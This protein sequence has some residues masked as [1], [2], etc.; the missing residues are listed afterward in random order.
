MRGIV[1]IRDG[2]DISEYQNCEP[3]NVLN[4]RRYIRLS[5]GVALI[6]SLSNS[7]QPT[8]PIMPAEIKKFGCSNLNI[9]H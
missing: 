9:L 2:P 1:K 8:K 5:L 7:L 3:D 4:E 6:A